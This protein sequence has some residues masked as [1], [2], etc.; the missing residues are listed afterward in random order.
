MSFFIVEDQFECD[1]CPPFSDQGHM[2]RNYEAT[3]FTGIQRFF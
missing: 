2:W 3:L 1:P